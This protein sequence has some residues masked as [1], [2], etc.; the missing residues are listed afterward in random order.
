MSSGLLTRGAADFTIYGGMDMH[1]QRM[2]AAAVFACA[3]ICGYAVYLA[4]PGARAMKVFYAW[5]TV[6]TVMLAGSFAVVL[7]RFVLL[8]RR[9]RPPDA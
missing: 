1:T 4:A 9:R 6:V 8:R 5:F 2:K 7:H 3:L